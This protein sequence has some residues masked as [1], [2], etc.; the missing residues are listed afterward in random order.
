VLGVQGPELL[1][2]QEQEDHQRPA[3]V[4]QVLSQVPEAHAA[5]R[6]EVTQ[7]QGRK[8]NG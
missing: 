5:Q 8:L 4:Q 7:K 1:D 6:A 2:D 3:G